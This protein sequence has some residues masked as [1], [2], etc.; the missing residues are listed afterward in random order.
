MIA[1]CAEYASMMTVGDLGQAT[2]PLA[3]G[4]VATL[5]TQLGKLKARTPQLHTGYQLP[6]AIAGYAGQI[7]PEGDRAGLYVALT[8]AVAGLVVLHQ[9]RLPIALHDR[10]GCAGVRLAAIVLARAGVAVPGMITCTHL[11][12]SERLPEAEGLVPGRRSGG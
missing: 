4:F 9:Q 8:R 12:M 6:E 10:R 2:H 1:P 7:L 5:L 3:A 11:G